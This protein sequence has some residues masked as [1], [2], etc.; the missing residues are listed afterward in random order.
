MA[1][2]KV[3]QDP[4]IQKD[5]ERMRTAGQSHNM[6]EM[7]ALQTCP[8]LQTD[9]RFLTGQWGNEFYSHQLQSYV[10]S[11]GDVKREAMRQGISV[12]GSGCTYTVR[13]DAPRD[14][15]LPYK[16]ADDIVENAVLD[17]LDDH[18]TALKDDPELPQKVRTKLQ[19]DWN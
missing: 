11:R 12:E 5:Y 7:L 6:A 1:Y 18:P 2:P 4:R 13:S 15:E 14:D 19:G 8:G 10:G 16:V 9:T 3:S 17:V